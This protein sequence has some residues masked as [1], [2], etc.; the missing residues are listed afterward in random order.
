MPFRETHH[1][2]GR[3]VALAEKERKP[4]DKLSLQQLRSVDERFEED[5]MKAFNY[6]SSV[7]TRTVKGGTS[8]KS[9]LEQI[10]VIQKMLE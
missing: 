5:V 1:I 9:V 8:R 10:E 7:E 2:S 4:M 3:V 6:E